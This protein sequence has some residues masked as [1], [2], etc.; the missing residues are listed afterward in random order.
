MAGQD[1]FAIGVDLGTSNTVAVVRWPDGRTRPLLV[2]GVSVLPSGVFLD[3]SG[4]LYVGRDAQRMAQ[5]DPA[6]YEPNPKRRIDEAAVLLG[7]R[8]VPVVDL[9]AAV[10]G[11]VARAAM[12]AV[13]FLPPAVLTYPAAWGP[14]RRDKLLAAAARAG[15]PPVRLVP[16]PVAAARYFADVLRRPVPVGSALAVFDFGGGTLDV[17]VVRNEGAGFAVLGCGGIS[18]LG[19]LDVDAALVEQL[20]G[21]LAATAPQAWRTV[22]RPES[23][24][25]RRGRRMFWEDVRG[26]KE[27]LSRGTVAPVAVPG[28]D[29]AVHITREELE[30]VAAPLVRRGVYETAAVINR[31]GLRPDQL[32]GLFLVGGSSRLP[33]V[34][35]MLHAELGIAPTVLEQPELPVAEGALA[36]LAPLGPASP[37]LT[38][39]GAPTSGAPTS[40]AL[41]LGALTSG[42]PVPGAPV[43][44]V[45]GSGSAPSGALTGAPGGIGPGAVHP[46][47][48]YPVSAAPWATGPLDPSG[49]LGAPGQVSPAGYFAAPGSAPPGS[50]T[51]G[52]ASPGHAS[53][54]GGHATGP[55]GPAG[56]FAAPV[57]PRRARRAVWVA[58]LAGAL[59]LAL[60]VTVAVTLLLRG[61]RAG[62]AVEFTTLI[63]VAGATVPYDDP[64][65]VD[66]AFTA[67]GGDRAYV[68]WVRGRTL[69]VAAIDLKGGR[70][71]WAPRT[72]ADA[73]SWEMLR[74]GAPAVVALAT[75]YA[76]SDRT[77]YVLNP[78]D[79]A[80]RWHRSLHRDDDALAFDSGLV[81]SDEHAHTTTLLDWRTGTEKWSRADPTDELSGTHKHVLDMST[82]DDLAGPAGVDATP[83]AP[84]LGDDHRVL[85]ITADKTL[86]VLDAATGKQL[87]SRKSVGYPDDT[88]LAHD[89]ALYVV[90]SDSPYR[91]LAYDLDKLGEP[92]VAYTADDRNQRL[93]R[94]A[95]CGSGR[96]CLL[97]TVSSD[98]ATT[99]V[100]S[101]DVTH[102]RQLWH[103]GAPGA[104]ELIPMG[105]RVLA[106]Q[107]TGTAASWL[108]DAA[109]KQ[110]L[111]AEDRPEVGARVTA[112]SLLMFSGQPSS[113]SGDIGLVGVGAG[114]GA[115][116]ALGQLTRV[117]SKDCSWSRTYLVCPGDKGFEVWRFVKT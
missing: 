71:L 75:N 70:Q 6:R 63:Q 45:P 34:A 35:R 72:V 68:G 96:V 10:L 37:A 50:A 89:G 61:A 83:F 28:V 62:G 40:G 59:A 26:A 13:G 95:P 104:E 98:D 93:Q 107:D 16:E 43:S 8:E 30:R 110:V 15:W 56:Y 9:L 105:D 46:G 24:V 54:G 5:L 41:T 76:S 86:T 11:A 17:A 116:T 102:H 114:D 100:R 7:D 74:A 42:A 14:P 38:A 31:C 67:T 108:F 113:Y 4:A 69:R 77:L 33:L 20:G 92:V 19:G 12:E 51:P 18:E 106:T 88:Y 39:A 21:V 84:N 91:L 112:A 82:V 81:V 49:T 115:R 64:A 53:P 111:R 101:I 3:G 48:A 87:A 2:D 25:E 80:Q 66:R 94:I 78:A 44:G 90:T 23:A 60:V 27:M 47:S 32:A 103:Q 109:G 65:K 79:G 22:S 55:I 73:D 52:S 36:E 58:A 57:P 1:G 97:D 117:R 99:Q 29:Q 85:R